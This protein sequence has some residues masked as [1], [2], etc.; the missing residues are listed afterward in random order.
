MQPEERDAAYL[1]DM[2]NAAR[3]AHMTVE[4]T[5]CDALMDVT[6]EENTGFNIALSATSTL[7]KAAATRPKRFAGDTAVTPACGQVNTVTLQTIDS[8]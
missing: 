4:D 3:E 5:A 6:G 7:G 1:W 8:E 2:L